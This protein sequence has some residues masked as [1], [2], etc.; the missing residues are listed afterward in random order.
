MKASIPMS[1]TLGLSGQPFSGPDLGG[2][3]GSPTPDLWASWVGFG[4]FFPFCRGH[5]ERGTPSK[6]PYMQG[7]EVKTAARIAPRSPVPPVAL[8]LHAFPACLGYMGEPIMQP[9]FFAD[10]TDPALRNEG[11]LPS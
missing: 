7:P 3:S 6:E 8:P 4:N 5:A 10:P 9:L 2:F 1:L 11:Q